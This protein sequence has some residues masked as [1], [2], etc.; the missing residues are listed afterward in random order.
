M[1]SVHATKVSG[2]RVLLY[3]MAAVVLLAIYA[4][5]VTDGFQT[6]PDWHTFSTWA[7]GEHP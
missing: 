6:A 2:K 1:R 7:N 5:W 4:G 3:G